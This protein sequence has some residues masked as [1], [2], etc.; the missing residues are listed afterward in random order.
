MQLGV[1]EQIWRYPVKSMGGEC[2]GQAVITEQGLAGDRCWAVL[3]A[4]TGEI[5]TAKRWTSL[6]NY[7]ASLQV[8]EVPNERCYEEQVPDVEIHCPDGSTITGRDAL[9]AS[10]LSGQLEKAA[11]LAPLAPP[12]NKDHYRLASARTEESMVEEMQLLPGESFPDFSGTPEALMMALADNV[13]PPGTYFDAYPLH[14]LTQNSLDYLSELGGVNAVVERYR[15][16]LLVK[17]TERKAELTENDWLGA[18]VQVGEAILSI[19]SRTVRCSMPSR[20]QLWCDLKAEKGM[21][22]AMLDHCERHLGVNIIVEQGGYV[23]VG[24]PLTQIE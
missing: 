5:C 4:E 18:R 9:A 13:T 6:L 24:D 11:M 14:L 20:E 22:R 15:P 3:N 8:T 2:V 19:H 12:E 10:R 17:P 23:S 1:V 21:A 7:R 16:N